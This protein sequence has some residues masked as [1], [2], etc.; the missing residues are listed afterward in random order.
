MP[1][2]KNGKTE[3][4]STSSPSSSSRP[5]FLEAP[6]KITTGQIGSTV[7]LRCRVSGPKP[8][9]NVIPGLVHYYF[10]HSHLCLEMYCKLE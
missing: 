5:Q 3:V 6:D 2:V 1:A 7:T 10:D 8:I 9:G 4:V